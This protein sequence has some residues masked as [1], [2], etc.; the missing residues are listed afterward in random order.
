MYRMLWLLPMLACLLPGC[1]TL[2]SDGDDVAGLQEGIRSGE[3]VAVGEQVYITTRDGGE[4]TL[5]VTA[6][7]AD[8]LYG[9]ETVDDLPPDA[10]Q[11]TGE[12]VGI[13]IGDIVHFE[14]VG[15]GPGPTADD[16]RNA[17]FLFAIGV[18]AV[19]AAFVNF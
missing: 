2:Q 7:D 3:A 19:I 16:F 11:G 13:A 18:M 14:Q 1:A 4:R 9:L 17:L 8:V 5:T 6:V 12:V 15:A 10:A